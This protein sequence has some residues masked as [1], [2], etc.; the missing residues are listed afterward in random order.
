[1]SI[2]PRDLRLTI[3]EEPLT[4]G[5]VVLAPLTIEDADE[6]GKFCDIA[7]F[8][9]MDSQLVLQAPGVDP[10]QFLRSWAMSRAAL[11]HLDFE[12]PIAMV[13][14]SFGV[15]EYANDGPL[16][17]IVG[18]NWIY[19]PPNHVNV[20]YWTEPSARG[21]EIATHAVMT[22]RPWALKAF[23]VPNAFIWA[24]SQASDRVA[25]KAGFKPLTGGILSW[26]VYSEGSGTPDT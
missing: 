22:A 16:A 21:R 3:P 1:M 12:L 25:E 6:V 20:Y 11:W 24:T 14:A 17:G 9:E 10:C 26:W 19:K 5:H 15:R 18:F 8:N 13:H 4:D 7:G 2:E 23:G